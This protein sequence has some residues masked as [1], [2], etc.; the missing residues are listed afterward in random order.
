VSG[1]QGAQDLQH[2]NKVAEELFSGERMLR[3]EDRMKSYE[4]KI[5]TFHEEMANLKTLYSQRDEIMI[6]LLKLLHKSMKGRY[7]LIKGAEAQLGK[8]K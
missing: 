2:I 6:E 4:D 1:V 8:N 7:F 3:L 5:N